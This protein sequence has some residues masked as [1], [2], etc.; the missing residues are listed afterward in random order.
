MDDFEGLKRRLTIDP[1][2]LDQELIQLPMLTMEVM[3]ITT[4]KLLERD[5]AKVA[6]D[7]AMAEA[8]DDLRG[9]LITDG[10]GNAKVRSEAQI[11][12]EVAMYGTVQAAQERLE[13]AKH[14]LAMWQALADAVRTK[15]DSLKIYADLTISGYL[16]PNYAYDQRKVE[17]R[18][19]SNARRRPITTKGE[20][21]Q[22]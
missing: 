22:W 20:D 12:T 16:S 11:D 6:L 4:D 21:A 19:A 5:Q 14:S 7:L 8:A 10:K 3:E 18:N 15:R 17:I 1:M 13:Q 9:K 2:E